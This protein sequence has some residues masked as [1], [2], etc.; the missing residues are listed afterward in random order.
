MRNSKAFTQII[1]F[2][3]YA[4][5]LKT[6]GYKNRAY[7]KSYALVKSSWKAL[8][9]RENV[10]F[11]QNSTSWIKCNLNRLV[12]I[13]R[14]KELSITLPMFLSYSR[15][16]S[17]SFTEVLLS[18]TLALLIVIGS[19]AISARPLTKQ[20]IG[21]EIR[22]EL[23]CALILAVHNRCLSIKEMFISKMQTHISH[24]KSYITIYLWY[25]Y[26]NNIM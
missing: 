2:Y 1:V 7:V 5:C 19:E 3:C 12:F 16:S 11:W 17:L 4:L 20:C 9:S 15:T 13:A 8:E 25:S 14:R 21:Y 23:S 10:T 6:T 18:A 26:N 22:V 24:L